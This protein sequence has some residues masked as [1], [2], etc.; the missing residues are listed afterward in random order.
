MIDEPV[1]DAVLNRATAFEIRRISRESS[2]LL[3]LLEDGIVKAAKG[4]T[5]LEEVLRTLP[6][7]DA[8]RPVRTLQRLLGEQ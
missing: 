2:G 8:P 5:T 3:S 1:R 6:R 7:L 4:I